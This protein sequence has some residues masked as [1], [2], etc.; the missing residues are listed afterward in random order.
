MLAGARIEVNEGKRNPGDFALWKGAKPGEPV[1]GKSL[2]KGT[3]R[4]AH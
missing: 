3:S 4:L 2:G 1:L